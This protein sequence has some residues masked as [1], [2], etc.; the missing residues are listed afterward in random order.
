MNIPKNIET[1]RLNLRHQSERDEAPFVNFMCDTEST[2]FSSFS[3]EQKTEDGAKAL[4]AY[5]ISSYK[6]NS[7]L[8]VLTAE[9]AKTR[10]F[11]GVCGLN[12]LKPDNEIEV[13][14]TVAV[15]QRGNGYG[16]EM[17]QCLINYLEENSEYETLIA[18]VMQDN[19]AAQKVALVSGFINGGLVVYEHVNEKVYKYIYKLKTANKANSADAKKPRG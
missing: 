14:Y 16:T 11:V 8:F 2:R 19:A 10:D 12:P 13:F 7:P 4:L 17:T 15:E 6:T 5:T 1:E 3:N 9:T 18:F